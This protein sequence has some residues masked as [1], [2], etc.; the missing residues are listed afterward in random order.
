MTLSYQLAFVYSRNGSGCGDAC[1]VILHKCGCGRTHLRTC[2]ELCSVHTSTFFIAHFLLRRKIACEWTL[3][4][5]FSASQCMCRNADLPVF[6]LGK[7][8]SVNARRRKCAVHFTHANKMCRQFIPTSR[9]EKLICTK[10]PSTLN[11]FPSLLEELSALM[12]RPL[13]YGVMVNTTL[14]IISVNRRNNPKS[15]DTPA[16]IVIVT[17]TT[18]FMI[19]RLNR[20]IRR[21]RISC[22]VAAIFLCY[23]L[24]TS[25][26]K[27]PL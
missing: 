4:D 18:D 24:K 21:T 7:C 1:A 22:C 8:V 12:T 17:P 3:F 10:T 19:P 2:W 20:I 27:N 5:A 23:F 6:P 26:R 9:N 13:R 15:T 14:Q 16:P 11:K 25:K